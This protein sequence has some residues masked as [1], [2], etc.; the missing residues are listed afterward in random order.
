M[1]FNKDVGKVVSNNGTIF[2]MNFDSN[3]LLDFQSLFAEAMSQCILINLFQMSIS[4]INVDIISC[5]PD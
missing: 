2:I 1:I 5:L 4:M 3:L